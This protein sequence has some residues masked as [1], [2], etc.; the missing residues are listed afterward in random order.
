MNKFANAS[1]PVRWPGPGAGQTADAGVAVPPPT[2]QPPGAGCGGVGRAALGA[3]PRVPPAGCRGEA[4]R[5]IPPAMSRPVIAGQLNVVHI[6]SL[7]HNIPIHDVGIWQSHGHEVQPFTPQSPTPS[8]SGKG[9]RDSLMRAIVPV[10]SSSSSSCTSVP[11]A[12]S[13]SSETEEGPTYR[14]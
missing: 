6:T 13:R 5:S 12:D 10:T 4:L 8:W 11:F 1:A 9:T 7:A 3:M 2:V 14:P